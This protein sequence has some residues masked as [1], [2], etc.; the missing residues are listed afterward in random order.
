MKNLPPCITALE[1]VPDDALLS[2]QVT[3]LAETADFL[4]MGSQC[5]KMNVAVIAVTIADSSI[6][7][8]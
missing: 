8:N 7:L 1:K 5:Y 4:N 3:G 6:K 2:E